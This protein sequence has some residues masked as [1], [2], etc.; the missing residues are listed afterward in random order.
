MNAHLATSAKDVV[1]TLEAP[2]GTN[3]RSVPTFVATPT[4]D[5]VHAA[6]NG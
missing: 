1:L 6:A 4:A 5:V 3:A 2:D